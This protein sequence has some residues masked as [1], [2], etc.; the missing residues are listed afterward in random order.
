MN[1]QKLCQLFL[2]SEKAPEKY[3]YFKAEFVF[4]IH[5]Q[6]RGNQD[7][8]SRGRRQWVLS[9]GM[10]ITISNVKTKL[11]LTASHL[12]QLLKALEQGRIFVC[13]NDV[14]VNQ[15]QIFVPDKYSIFLGHF[16]V[17]RELC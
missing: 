10:W 17:K 8:K 6:V 1:L 2:W 14:K 3:N 5:P 12:G 15:P 4:T 13:A 16:D 11:C 7:C 9:P